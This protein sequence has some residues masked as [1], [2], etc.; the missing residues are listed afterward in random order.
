MFPY[1]ENKVKNLN[2]IITIT[3]MIIIISKMIIK[4]KW[5]KRKDIL[6]YKIILD[7]VLFRINLA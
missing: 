4:K 5:I 7:L 3:M 6:C 2:N 1:F